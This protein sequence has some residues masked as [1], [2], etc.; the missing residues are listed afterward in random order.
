[1]NTKLDLTSNVGQIYEGSKRNYRS[2]H[3]A[4]DELIKKYK[5]RPS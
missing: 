2:L 5:Q 1:M 3:T 4:P